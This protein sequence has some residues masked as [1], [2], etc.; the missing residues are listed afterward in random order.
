M[1]LSGA[2]L[3]LQSAILAGEILFCLLFAALLLHRY[4][5]HGRSASGWLSGILL[6]SA[7]YLVPWAAG[8]LG[9]YAD[10]QTRDLLFYVPFQQLLLLG[11]FI[12]FYIRALLDPLRPWQKRDGLHLVPGGIYLLGALLVWITDTWFRDWFYFYADGRDGDLSPWYQVVGLS[13]IVLY[14][15]VSIGFYRRYRWQIANEV[16]YSDAITFVWVRR[17]LLL[18]LAVVGLRVAFLVAFP[19]FGSFGQKFWYYFL[20][21]L[22]SCTV[23]LAGYTEAVRREVSRHLTLPPLQAAA[24]E[25]AAG[26][27]YA[28]ISR[29]ELLAWKP[30]LLK[31]MQD[32]KPYRDPELSLSQLAELL[33][34]SR[35]QTSAL[36][37]REFERN[38][39]D[40]INGYRLQSV[41]EALL[42]GEHHR[43]TLL[44]IALDAGFN[45]KSTFNRVFKREIGQTP[46]QFLASLP[47]K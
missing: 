7:L 24:P 36:I 29:E 25:P 30:R 3:S 8:H 31:L 9:W 33:G 35:R 32:G 1:D 10:P 12:Y 45:S 18:L 44:A 37:N 46:R 19:E 6:L 27:S 20:S 23:G 26:E 4:L 11:P 34:L 22:I 41:R 28:D 16:S 5:R 47:E 38:F 14:T 39:N 43:H 13:S 40:F 21:G 42:R 17:Y 15:L 2:S